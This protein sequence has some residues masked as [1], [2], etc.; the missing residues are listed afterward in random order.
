MIKFSPVRNNYSYTKFTSNNQQKNSQNNTNNQQKIKTNIASKIKTGAL[1]TTAFLAGLG[2]G[3][4]IST[5]AKTKTNEKIQNIEIEQNTEKFITPQEGRIELKKQPNM[6]IVVN[7]TIDHE[8][9]KYIEERKYKVMKI[10]LMNE[11]SIRELN[12]GDTIKKAEYSDYEHIPKK[13]LTQNIA[14]NTTEK[15]IIN[16]FDKK[17]IP[18]S[19]DNIVYYT[20]GSKDSTNTKPTECKISYQHI[21][22][23]I[24]KKE[25]ADFDELSEIFL[26]IVLGDD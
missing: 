23:Q 13:T 9:G 2:I 5:E 1:V 11:Q 12:S 22:P 21:D 4:N 25:P 20:D 26:D 10:A 16:G 6:T 18:N 17:Y 3:N 14:D 15:R 8:T 19:I 24:E 7:D